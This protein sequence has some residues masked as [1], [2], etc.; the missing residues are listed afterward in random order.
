MIKEYFWI[1]E[2]LIECLI[3]LTDYLNQFPLDH[4][5]LGLNLFV[6]L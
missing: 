6:N 2:Y 4:R 1:K 3:L 5:Q